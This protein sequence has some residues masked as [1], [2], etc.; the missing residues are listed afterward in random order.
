LDSGELA[1]V[2]GKRHSNESFVVETRHGRVEV[3][4]T[5]FSVGF[6]G[7][8]SWVRVDEG[9]V[10]AF[11]AKDADAHAVGAGQTF[12]LGPD[13]SA[14]VPSP[15][16]VPSEGSDTFESD[17]QPA[18][19]GDCI[20]ATARARRAMRGGQPS[21]ALRLLDERASRDDVQASQ[22][23]RDEIGYLRA[24]ALRASGRPREAILAYLR[25][26]RHG[27]EPAMR[28]NALFA[29]GELEE[30]T[31]RHLAAHRRFEAALAVAPSGGLREEAMERA[32]QAAFAG[33]E[34]ALAR[35][36]AQRYLRE[37]PGG[38]SSPAAR[39]IL[40]ETTSDGTR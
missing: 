34:T 17:P 26:D 4:G 20:T 30:R 21:R 33:R 11:R 39:R 38:G 23:C 24:E 37:F 36:A 32:M 3:R 18:P 27:A 6:A 35:A 40:R 31:G 8:S 7:A 22:R 29:A 28:Q 2:L 16:V 13:S 15:A 14:L 12:W 19:A 10:A 5:R 25:L 9:L 1:L